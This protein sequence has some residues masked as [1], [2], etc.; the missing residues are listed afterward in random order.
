MVLKRQ[1]TITTC[2]NKQKLS[3]AK[4]WNLNTYKN[5][6]PVGTVSLLAISY[7]ALG[8]NYLFTI[9]IGDNIYDNMRRYFGEWSGIPRLVCSSPDS[10]RKIAV[11]HTWSVAKFV[12]I[13][14]KIGWSSIGLCPHC[15]VAYRA[16]LIYKNE[17]DWWKVISGSPIDEYCQ[18]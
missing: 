3:I 18:L 8:C 12:I 2:N 1:P 17:H 11:I 14:C 9:I 15:N 5:L 6:L 7:S 13:E 16:I 4:F 10:T